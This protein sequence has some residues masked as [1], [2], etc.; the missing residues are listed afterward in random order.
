M[1]GTQ[2]GRILVLILSAILGVWLVV[3]M[4]WKNEWHRLIFKISYVFFIVNGV[5]YLVFDVLGLF[6]LD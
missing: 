5:R 2:V 1:S 6:P 3:D 4:S